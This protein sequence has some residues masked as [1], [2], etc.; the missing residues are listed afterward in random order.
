MKQIYPYLETLISLSFYQFCLD[1]IISTV[2]LYIKRR[3]YQL[4]GNL[5][6]LKGANSSGSSIRKIHG[7]YISIQNK[8]IALSS[9]V[10]EYTE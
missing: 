1:T 10:F 9:T 7:R 3:L 8:S 6:N 2:I 4:F 5:L